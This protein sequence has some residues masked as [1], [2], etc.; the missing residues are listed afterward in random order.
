[1]KKITVADIIESVNVSVDPAT[2]KEGHVC[3]IYKLKMK[4]HIPIHYPV[5]TDVTLEDWEE[6]LRVGFVRGL[7]DAIQ[8][9]IVLLGKISG[10]KDYKDKPNPSNGVNNDHSNESESNRNDQTDD[11]DDGDADDTEDAEDL[12]LDAQ[13]NKQQAMDEVEYEDGSE[14]ETRDGQDD[15]DDKDGKDGKGDGDGDDSNIEVNGDDSDIDVND[16]DKKVAL[17]ANNSQGLEETSKSEK[18]KSEAEFKENDRR[19]YVK[20]RGMR[21]EIHFKFTDDEPHILLGQVLSNANHFLFSSDLLFK[22]TQLQKYRVE[23]GFLFAILAFSI[24]H[25]M[26]KLV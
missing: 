19:I 11:D 21:F 12:G 7:E 23:C 2:A 15:E 8:S 16:N 6:T 20:A 5:H 1:M 18:R 17:D 14:E 13:K 10:I 22:L 25:S 3:R 26:G 4:L 24:T 9:H